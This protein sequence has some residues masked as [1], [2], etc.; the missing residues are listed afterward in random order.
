M[1]SVGGY[2]VTWV[3]LLIHKQLLEV[4]LI[5]MVCM[6]KDGLEGESKRVVEGRVEYYIQWMCF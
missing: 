3:V 5:Q 1:S 6:M 4:I 2:L